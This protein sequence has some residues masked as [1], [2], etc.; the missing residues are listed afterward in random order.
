MDTILIAN[1]EITNELHWN[2]Y[3]LKRDP[4]LYHNPM[5]MTYVYV[6]SIELIRLFGINFLTAECKDFDHSS[7]VYTT[8]KR[9][10]DRSI[11]IALKYVCVRA[12]LWR[13][14]KSAGG[15]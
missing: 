14:T 9:V 8:H 10:R 5:H 12:T 4:Q 13:M 2:V 3:S 1:N 15:S 6:I 11:A 7:Q